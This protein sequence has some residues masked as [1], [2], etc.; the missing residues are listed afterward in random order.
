MTAYITIYNMRFLSIL[1]VFS[2]MQ[3]KTERQFGDILPNNQQTLPTSTHQVTQPTP[4]LQK[5]T[6]ALLSAVDM[7][8][9]VNN[10]KSSPYSLWAEYF[11]N[12]PILTEFDLR[13][14]VN[15]ST[16]SSIIS[17]SSGSCGSW[18][19]PGSGSPFSE[20]EA[21]ESPFDDSSVPTSVI[22]EIVQT[23]KMDGYNFDHLSDEIIDVPQHHQLPVKQ[24]LD[25]S[26][27]PCYMQNPVYASL[28]PPKLQQMDHSRKYSMTSNNAISAMNAINNNTMSLN[29]NHT[30][31]HEGGL[32]DNWCT[33]TP[34][35]MTP[36]PP[37][38]KCWSY[39]PLFS[40]NF[41]V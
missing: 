27:Q 29:L 17:S 11:D 23:L 20:C 16:G 2:A 32:D 6:N 14:G 41:A 12:F 15:N 39:L 3:V 38:S 36:L 4:T 18:S 22:D 33:S 24:E 25:M 37:I 8:C 31:S 21:E 34:S 40:Y 7:Q 1:Q 19:S 30:N 10:D 26:N 5:P 13:S 9:G 28:H 35:N